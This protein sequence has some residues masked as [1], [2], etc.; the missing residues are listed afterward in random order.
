[1]MLIGFGSV[2]F[3]L[4]SYKKPGP[5]DSSLFATDMEFEEGIRCPKCNL[6]MTEGYL[7]TGS[8]IVWRNIDQPVGIPTV[9]SGLPGTA[10]FGKHSKLHAYHCVSCK[11]VTFKYGKNRGSV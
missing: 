6:E 1:M 8:G 9:F 3:V 4:R 11:I 7:P 10:I 2:F 5:G